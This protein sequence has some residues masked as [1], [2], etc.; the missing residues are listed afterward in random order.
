MNEPNE[1]H[2]EN[3]RRGDLRSVRERVDLLT[4]DLRSIDTELDD[5]E[6]ERT[7]YGLLQEACVALDSL[8]EMG[9]SDL[10]WRGSDLGLTR[11][12]H[13]RVVRGRVAAF[14]KRIVD[15]EER[16]QGLVDEIQG[17]EDAADEIAGDILE[18]D[19]IAEQ[20]KLEWVIERDEEFPITAAILPWSR[21]DEG[22]RLFRKSLAIA[23][24]LCLFLGAIFPFIDI[25]LPEGWKVLEEQERLT[26]LIR[27]EIATP[28]PIPEVAPIIPDEKVPSEAS[29]EPILAE[30]AAA[31]EEPAPAATKKEVASSGILAFR[32]QLSSLTQ[33]NAVDRL[34][35][36]ARL[37][38]LGNAAQGMPQRAMVTTQAP[39]S[40]GGINVAKLSRDT[41]GTGKGMGGVS[42]SQATSTIGN[43][44]GSDRPLAG[45]G[46]GLGRTDEDIQIVFDRHKAALYRLYNRALRGNPTLKGQI[47]LRL[48]IEPDGSVSL[49]EVKSSNM[50]APEL[51]RKVVERVKTFD[52]GAKEGI[53]AVTIVYPIDFLPAT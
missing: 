3:G 11:P 14:E 31:S 41:G 21:S 37:Q 25:P 28:P 45:G 2:D 29:E 43:G 53:S 16:R 46:P 19:R 49:C 40:S 8:D 34:G 22:D 48:T 10:F 12:D 9:A 24:L 17:R 50:K 26:Q 44:G 1:I 36:N 42:V 15:I 38:D 6:T 18:A 39:G 7:Q 47:V 51:S 23:L 52:F 27:K 4:K 32:D 20:K 30:E 5:I 35:S 13:L 33:N